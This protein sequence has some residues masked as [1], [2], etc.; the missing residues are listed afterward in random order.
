MT[1]LSSPRR[2]LADRWHS[3]AIH[4]L[5]RVRRRDAE[6]GV[7]PAQ[8]S[9]LSVVVFRDGITLGELAAAEQVRPPTLT[10]VVRDL[11]SS[12]LVRRAVDGG[13]RRITHVHATAR[14]RR[15]LQEG[16]ERRIAELEATLADLGPAERG[17]L[18]R[19]A[20]VLEARLGARH[21][22]R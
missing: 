6:S 5:R 1:R 9:A 19:A 8:L 12:G 14:G 10:R 11:E 15:V 18:A 4:L 3:L 16:R 21:E 22:R 2:E 17:V 13:D 7:G 20:D